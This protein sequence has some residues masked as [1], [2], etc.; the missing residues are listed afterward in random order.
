[1]FTGMILVAH[2]KTWCKAALAQT[3]FANTANVLTSK[4]PQ[5]TIHI[6]LTTELAVHQATYTGTTIMELKQA[7][8]WYKAE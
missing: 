1:M 7:Y 2:S 4:Q 6:F 5:L 8:I 3:W